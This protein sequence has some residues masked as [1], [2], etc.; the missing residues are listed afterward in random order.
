LAAGS[1]TSR[2]DNRLDAAAYPF[3]TARENLSEAPDDEQSQDGKPLA[4]S[5]FVSKLLVDLTE[6]S[7]AVCARCCETYC[8]AK[9]KTGRRDANV[10]PQVRFGAGRST[11]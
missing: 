1:R 3:L 4:R 5:R 10:S 7:H 2:V 6:L 11:A 9:A 8:D